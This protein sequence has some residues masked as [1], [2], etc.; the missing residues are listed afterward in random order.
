VKIIKAHL[1]RP[2]RWW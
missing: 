1:Q 2:R